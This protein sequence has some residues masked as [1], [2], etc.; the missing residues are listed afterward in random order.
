MS[1]D[2]DLVARALPNYEVGAE[3]GRGAWGI[4][5]A[6]RHRQLDRAVAIKQ[7]PRAFGADAAVRT[8]FLSE[9][10]VLASLDHP[11]IV[12][13][14]DYVE[15]EGLCLLVMEHLTGGTVWSR[16]TLNGLEMQTACAVVLAACAGLQCAHD[17]DVL[18]RDIKPENL[19]FSAAGSVKVADFGI[20][21]VISGSETMATRAG[22]VLGTPAYMAPEQARGDVLGPA[23]DV[24]A[25][26]TMLYEL[27]SGRLPFSEEGDALAVLYRHVND[28][29]ESLLDVAPTVPHAIAAVVMR[30]IATRVDDRY[31]SADELSVDLAAAA[32]AAWGPGW[33]AATGVPVLSSGRN[34]VVTPTPRSAPAPETIDSPSVPAV[35]TPVRPSVSVHLPKSAVSDFAATD[36]VPVRDMVRVAPGPRVPALVAVGLALTAVAIALV[37]LSSPSRSGA[38]DIRVN[39]IDPGAVSAVRLDLAQPVHIEGVVAA[40]APASRLR[41]SFSAL[42]LPLGDATTAVAPQGGRFAVDVDTSGRRYLVAGGVTPRRA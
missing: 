5:L 13:L 14:Y 37:G 21:K 32:E 15:Q 23:T 39:G 38:M 33:M 7:L 3:L 29:P 17:H 34:P 10:R 25:V 40:A 26:G 1:L 4:V 19:L 28:P 36:L 42:G 20:A 24:Y 16:F 6:G 27:L 18:H 30:S 11:H 41:M 2:R 12:P 9:A 22:D 35:T 8:R 31:A